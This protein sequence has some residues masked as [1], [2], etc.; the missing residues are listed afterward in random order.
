MEMQ[1]I[2]HTSSMSKPATAPCYRSKDFPF[3]ITLCIETHPFS[4]QNVLKEWVVDAELKRI[5]GQEWYFKNSWASSAAKVPSKDM[6]SIDRNSL[7]SPY[8][9]ESERP[10]FF[11]STQDDNESVHSTF[12]D[13]DGFYSISLP[14]LELA[15]GDILG[16]QCT[17][18][19]LAEGG[20]H[21]VCC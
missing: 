7:I 14:K 20:N 18:R 8:I 15:V 9:K 10:H 1:R 19:K 21:K 2:T 5:H 11:M 4:W 13:G 16:I 3:L 12:S 17:L 6:T